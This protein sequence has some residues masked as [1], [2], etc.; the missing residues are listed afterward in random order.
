MEEYSVCPY[1][2]SDMVFAVEQQHHNASIVSSRRTDVSGSVSESTSSCSNQSGSD[3]V[4]AANEPY[5][6]GGDGSDT[7]EEGSVEVVDKTMRLDSGNAVVVD[8]L[9][10][11]GN[12]GYHHTSSAAAKS[13]SSRSHSSKSSSSQAS[14]TNN[15]SV[16]PTG[17]SS[18]R[19]ASSVPFTYSYADFSQVL[20]A[21][22]RVL[23]VHND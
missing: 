4:I 9:T 2:S 20:S 13:L 19:S 8:Y 21:R 12:N 17:S 5:S 18:V 15:S 7:S 6:P 1:C 3:V 16:R 23:A 14:H 11:N 22:R 10:P